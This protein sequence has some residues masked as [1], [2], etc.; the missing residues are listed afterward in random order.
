M[1]ARQTRQNLGGG[2]AEGQPRFD[3]EG[4]A[5]MFYFLRDKNITFRVSTLS[6]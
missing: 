5:I 4:V 2:G 3:K 1:Q 6:D